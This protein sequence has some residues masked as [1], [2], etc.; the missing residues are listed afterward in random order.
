MSRRTAGVNRRSAYS[1]CCNWQVYS[2]HSW[3]PLDGWRWVGLVGRV[4]A[5]HGIEHDRDEPYE[6][7]L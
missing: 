1:A 7:D 3:G 6:K 2:W 4:D 5:Q